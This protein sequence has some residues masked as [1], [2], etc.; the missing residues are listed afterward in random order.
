MDA[1]VLAMMRDISLRLLQVEAA[2][3]FPMSIAEHCI[4]TKALADRKAALDA[5]R[6]ANLERNKAFHRA[7]A[8]A[9]RVGHRGPIDDFVR[10]LKAGEYEAT[11]SKHALPASE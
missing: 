1:D 6:Q 2:L 5:S 11:K 10:K 4:A 7:E 3:D 8:E 9:E